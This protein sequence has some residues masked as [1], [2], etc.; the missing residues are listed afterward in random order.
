MHTWESHNPAITQSVCRYCSPSA[1]RVAGNVDKPTVAGVG[2]DSLMP[3]QGYRLCALNVHSLNT[4]I[5]ECSR[6][7]LHWRG[8]ASLGRSLG[9]GWALL[10]RAV[11]VVTTHGLFYSKACT[12]VW[13]RERARR[14]G[15]GLSL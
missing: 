1:G 2:I 14:A 15:E 5:L 3:W 12:E 9:H 6:A 4:R 8:Q 13:A 10:R 7:M 11:P